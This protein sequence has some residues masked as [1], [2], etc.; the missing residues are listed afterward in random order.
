[1]LVSGCKSGQDVAGVGEGLQEWIW[2]CRNGQEVAKVD[3]E[4]QKWTRSCRSGSHPLL[5]KAN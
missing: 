4:L 1:M 3:K 2:N 5:Y